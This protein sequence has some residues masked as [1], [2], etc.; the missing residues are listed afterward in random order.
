MY[1]N[2]LQHKHKTMHG[3]ANT[4][5][6]ASLVCLG[7][8]CGMFL[9]K[10]DHIDICSHANAV[11]LRIKADVH[12]CNSNMQPGSHDCYLKVRVAKQHMQCAW[13]FTS[14][15]SPQQ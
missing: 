1:I 8:L 6:V 2:I 7:Q 15:S 14:A 13:V 3:Q 12:N 5:P 10:H 11:R 4:E 9:R